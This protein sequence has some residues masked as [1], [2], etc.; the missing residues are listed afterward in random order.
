MTEKERASR[1]CGSL[2]GKEEVDQV[3]WGAAMDLVGGTRPLSL[4]LPC[5]DLEPRRE[6]QIRTDSRT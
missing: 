1:L 4:K 5:V 3:D 2:E 6:A